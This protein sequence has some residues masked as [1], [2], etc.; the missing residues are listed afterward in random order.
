MDKDTLIRLV[1]EAGVVGEGGAGFPAHVKYNATAEVVIANGCECEPLLFSDQQTMIRRADEVVRGLKA[2]AEAVGAKRAVLAIKRKY[3]QAAEALERAMAGS[4]LELAGLDNFYPAGDEQILIHEITGRTVPPLGLPKDVGCLVANVGTLSSVSRALDGKPVT[5][6]VVTVTGEVARP[7][8]VTTPIGTSVRE[9]IDF[10]GGFSVSDPV[11][12]MGGP[13]MGRFLDGDQAL[14]AAVI[15]KTSGGIIV[16]PRDS[17]LYEMASLTPETMQRRAAVSC[18]Q[19]R[20]CTEL[21]PRF[22]IGQGFQTHKVMRAFGGG[23]VEAAMGALQ[24]WMCCECGVCELFSCPMGLSPRRINAMLKAQFRAEGAKYEGPREIAP[25]QS[26]LRDYRK[27]PVPRLA[28]RI[29]I[30]R[31]MG[32]HPEDVGEFRPSQVSIPILQH[33]GAEA[34]AQVQPGQRV[35]LGDCVGKIPEGALGANIHA[36]IGGVVASVGTTIVIQGA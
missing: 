21:C 35:S 25:E 11:V 30:G 23:G 22:L 1:R 28:E 32:I 24:A 34:V 29:G 3:V 17:R 26:A 14:N 5:D 18:I 27:V 16:L 7:S 10:C 19:C 6:K 33:I 9:L 15:T 2:V 13:M 36:S 8:V 12:L 31:Y 4:D 20:Y